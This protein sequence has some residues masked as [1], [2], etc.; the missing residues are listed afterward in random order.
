MF[1][2][3]SVSRSITQVP[4]ITV[5]IILINA[6][7]FYLEMQQ[8]DA[9]ITRWSAVPDKIVD[10]RALETVLTSAFMHAG[11]LHI[12]GNMV[13]LWAFAPPMEEAM[14]SV[15][16]LIF[17]VLGAIAAAAAHIYGDP[18]S[19][20]PIV[21]ASGAVAAVMGA[22]LVT[23]PRDSI[24]TL[25]LTPAVRVIYIPAIVLIGLWI[26]L[27]V[28]SVTTEPTQANTGGVAYLAHIGGAAFGIVFG[29]LFTWR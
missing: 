3:G 1:P 13:F 2:L 22:F 5:L 26:V 20:I 16:F 14:G 7:V 12:I 4:F 23:Y 11:W 21:G 25:V 8:G 28:V 17:Y 10:G 9:F 27:Q 19:T 6:G 29:R 24:R 15:K 18:N